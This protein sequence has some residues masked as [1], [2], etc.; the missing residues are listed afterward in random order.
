M[1]THEKPISCAQNEHDSY[2]S[3]AASPVRRVHI[4]VSML[5]VFE[6]PYRPARAP[7]SR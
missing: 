3:V 4:S 2:V 6:Q 5:V 1:T 7:I